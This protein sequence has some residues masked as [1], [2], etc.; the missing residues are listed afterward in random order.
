M[1]LL[2]I[3]AGNMGFTYVKSISDSKIIEEENILILENSAERRAELSSQTNYQIFEKAED[4]VPQADMIMLA[5]KPQICPE[6]FPIV[7]EYI[8]EDQLVI[9][10]MA[11]VKIKTIQEG[12]GA[13][14][15]VRVMP[16]LPSQ[17]GLGMSTYTGSA[18]VDES[19]MKYV[20][21]I[22][23]TTGS[24][25]A[26]NT[27]DDIDRSTGISGSGP[28]FIFFF[29]ESL[30]E[31]AEEFGFDH[32]TARTMASQTFKGAV[33][34]YLSSDL[35]T[36]EWMNRV[37]SKGGTTRAGLNSLEETGVKERI[38]QCSR[39]AYERAMELGNS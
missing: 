33:D 17:I 39:A 27:E 37:A 7:K 11:G 4:C 16:N 21:S 25:I 3:G 6:L 9:S 30:I 38:K 24:A 13:K 28:A 1:K 18:E 10:V 35:S 36:T 20:A 32:E 34:L 2:V 29:L 14:K 23:Q 5:I 31:A 19:E 22:L 26:V 15:V 8:R 12:L